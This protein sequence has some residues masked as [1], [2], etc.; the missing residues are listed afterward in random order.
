V[1]VGGVEIVPVLDAVGDLCELA[2]AYPDVPADAWE[3]YRPLYPELFS[4]TRWRLP[5]AVH[6]VRSGGATV[7][8]DTGVGPAGLWDFWAAEREGLL[9]AA[10][11]QLGVQRE[12]IDVVFLSHLHVDHLGWNTDERSDVFFPRARYVTHPDAL[13]FALA[14]PDRPHIKRCLEPLLDRIKPASDGIELAP[15][16]IARA[17]PGHYP[18]HMGVSIRSEGERAELIADTV[19]HPALL[20]ERAWVFA[21]DDFEPTPTRAHLVE[22]VL[23]TDCVV[24]CGHYPGS[25]IGRVVSRDG[26]VVWEELTA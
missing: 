19:P 5:V 15:G 14:R 10:L 16:V 8:V 17:L 7:L 22:E 4:G 18:G 1:V 23:D 2:H 9:P 21:L 13:A 25:G 24:V 6:L 11:D 12:E 20:D 3:P 26:R